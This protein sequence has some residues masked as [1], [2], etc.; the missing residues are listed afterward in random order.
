MG[1]RVRSIAI[2]AVAG[3]LASGCTEAG[4][5]GHEATSHVE[6][7]LS[8]LR[9][10]DV[11]GRQEE[12]LSVL[13]EAVLRA[14][15]RE[16]GREAFA[17]T[18]F[19][20][21]FEEVEVDVG[22]VAFEA[23]VWSRADALL[24]SGNASRRIEEDGFQVSVPLEAEDAVLV[25]CP[26]SAQLSRLNN[27]S[28]SLRVLNPGSDTLAVR[29]SDETLRCD[30]EPCLWIENSLFVVHPHSFVTVWFGSNG[31]SLGMD[32][33]R[34]ASRV[35]DLSVPVETRPPELTVFPR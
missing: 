34:V 33:L 35:G 6:I 13:D 4:H 7:D 25:V 27:Y 17:P 19:S 30:N 29:V 8:A 32:S 9:M 11:A 18:A 22:D 3:M 2:L 16:V 24:F 12:C 21:I 15:G 5:L 1:T 20:V 10:Q 31:G 26:A 28:D 14:N 23:A